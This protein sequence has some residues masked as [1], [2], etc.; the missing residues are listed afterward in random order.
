MPLPSSTF[1]T[2]S[3]LAK[4][5]RIVAMVVHK[6]QMYVATEQNVFLIQDGCLRKLAFQKADE[7]A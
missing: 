6:D 7:P 4:G 5:E 1:N 3:M 2:F